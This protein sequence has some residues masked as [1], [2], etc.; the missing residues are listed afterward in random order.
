[1]NRFFKVVAVMLTAVL[2]IT[3]PTPA[4]SQKKRDKPKPGPTTKP[5]LDVI[6]NPAP[7]YLSGEVNITVQGDENP[8]IRLQ[9]VPSGQAL[10]EFPA[11]DRI[12]KVNPADPDLVTIEDS[13]TKE[14]DRY[15]L[16]RS[17]KQFLEGARSSTDPSS[18]TS[19]LVQM[20]SGMVITLLIYPVGELEKVVHRCVVKYDR[21]SIVKARQAAGLAVNLDQREE[22]IASKTPTSIQIL[23]LEK[24]FKEISNASVSNSEIVADVSDSS[25]TSTAN[26]NGEVSENRQTPS[27]PRK[28]IKATESRDTKKG[29][30]KPIEWTGK[31]RWSEPLH[32]LKVAAQTRTLTADLRQV[33]ITVQNTL[34]EPIKIAPGQPELVIQTLDDRDCVLQVERVEPLKIEWSVSNGLIKDGAEARYVITYEAPVLGAKQ[35]LCA[36]VA[37]INAAD[38]PVMIEITKGTR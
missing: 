11:K 25:T 19:M 36:A 24:P 3:E 8:I 32:G 38:D 30:D 33:L 7:S 22:K 5:P 21:D 12:F 9:M 10:V 14:I 29:G 20:T 17:S 13:P 15:I 27:N 2:L 4:Q 16:L 28:I 35:R 1:M 18:A 6:N 34:S 31:P 37:Q 26:E 23:P